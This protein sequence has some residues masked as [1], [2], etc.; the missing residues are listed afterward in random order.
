MARFDTNWKEKKVV[1]GTV[2]AGGTITVDVDD[3]VSD[4]VIITSGLGTAD[5]VGG[6]GN[7]SFPIAAGYSDTTPEVTQTITITETGGV[8]PVDYTIAYMTSS[9][10]V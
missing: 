10:R 6:I 5:I 1:N 4:I 8:D 2:A 7:A 3:A 9:R